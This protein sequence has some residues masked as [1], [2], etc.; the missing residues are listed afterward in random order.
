[1]LDS[2]LW[3]LTWSKVSFSCF[4]VVQIGTNSWVQPYP[5]KCHMLTTWIQMHT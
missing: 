2:T 5:M 1:L 3:D 4:C